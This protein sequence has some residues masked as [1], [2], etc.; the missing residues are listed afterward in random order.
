MLHHFIDYE[1]A[2]E[3]SS[4]RLI[5]FSHPMPFDDFPMHSA[6]LG[7][8]PHANEFSSKV[9][10]LI[11]SVYVFFNINA[12]EYRAPGHPK[13]FRI[14]ISKTTDVPVSIWHPWSPISSFYAVCLAVVL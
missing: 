3:V 13:S 12:A 4:E 8:F 2:G 6:S 14:A 9:G 5:L 1:S 10:N 11:N 7:D